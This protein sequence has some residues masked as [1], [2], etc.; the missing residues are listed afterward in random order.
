MTKGTPNK[1]ENLEAPKIKRY[2]ATAKQYIKYGGNHLAIGDEF[3]IA[4]KDFKE[5]SQYA[6][7]EVEVALDNDNN[8]D[9]DSK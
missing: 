7:I 8:E 6:D 3:D 1:K 2:K 4:E 9:G 5:L